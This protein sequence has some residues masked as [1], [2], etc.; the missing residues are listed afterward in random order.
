[1][2]NYLRD[3]LYWRKSPI[4]EKELWTYLTNRIKTAE[5]RVAELEAELATYKRSDGQ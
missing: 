1:M 2:L 4:T 5:A 3:W